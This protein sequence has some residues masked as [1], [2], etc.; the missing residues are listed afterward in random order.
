M[1]IRGREV[2]VR[3]IIASGGLRPPRASTY[4]RRLP[5]DPRAHGVAEEQQSLQAYHA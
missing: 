4:N 3:A 1:G 5:E 2:V